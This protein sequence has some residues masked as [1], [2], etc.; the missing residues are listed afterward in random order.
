MVGVCSRAWVSI[1]TEH[2]IDMELL[3]NKLAAYR[4]DQCFEGFELF[5]V[6][7]S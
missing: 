2:K 3:N 6:L 5:L 7:V 4:A 1:F